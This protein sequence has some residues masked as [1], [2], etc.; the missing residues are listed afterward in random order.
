MR[1][2]SDREGWHLRVGDYRII[3]EIDDEQRI[4]TI[5]QVGPRRDI[6]R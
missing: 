6:Y 2:L 4:T 1:K 5:L 3:Y